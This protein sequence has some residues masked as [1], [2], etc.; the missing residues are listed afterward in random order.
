MARIRLASIILAA[1]AATMILLDA[2]FPPPIEKITDVSAYAVDREGRWLH[3]FAASEGRWR[4]A[5]DL[6]DIDPVF[7]E[8]LVR[9]EDRRFHNHPGV[10]GAAI[11]RASREAI[12][13]RRIVSGASTI[14]MQ[15]ARLLEP[16]PRTL[17]SKILEAFRALQIER[18][19]SKR[20]ILAAYLTLAPYGGNIEGVRAASLIYFGKEPSRLTDAEQ[21]LLIALPQAPEARRPDRRPMAAR[22]ARDAMLR[23]MLKAGLIT[24]QHAREAA[25]TSVPSMR[26]ELPTYAYHAAKENASTDATA[27]T[28]LDL[29][30]QSE[31]EALISRHAEQLDPH[32]TIAAVIVDHDSMAVRAAVGSTGFHVDGGWIDL[33]RAVR[34]PGSTLKPMIYAMAMDDGALGPDTLIGDMPRAFD[35][36]AP[37]N[38]DKRFRG[39]V[40]VSEALRHSLNVP[41]VAALDAIGARRFAASLRAAGF[42]LKTPASADRTDTLALALGGA[43]TRALDLATLYA[44]LANDGVMQDL[45]WVEN[46]RTDPSPHRLISASAAKRVSAILKE[47]PS[48]EGRAPSSLSQLAPGVAYKTGTS[49]G[50]RD[51][52]AA[53]YAG[54]YTVV[55]WVGRADGAPRPGMTGRKAAAPL[56]FDLFDAL[57]R[58]DDSVAPTDE[59]EMSVADASPDRMRTFDFAAPEIIFPRNG[60]ELFADG[61]ERA[62]SARG[63]TG[64]LRWYV[65]GEPVARDATSGRPLWR[66]AHPGFYGITVVDQ[67]GREA[68]AEIRVRASL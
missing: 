34:S 48:L 68:H 27:R 7:L 31:T 36:Y 15:T 5:A 32:A 20:E 51:A 55:V 13:H 47:A 25:A 49:Y 19:L 67:S 57:S 18:R 8:R 22:A 14:T 62:L 56:L 50:Y 1:F 65:D 54:A 28:T 24:S 9:I 30:M 21:A 33:T 52:W 58:H 29:L 2:L 10:D 26:R 38:F 6:D 66:P 40:S 16:R 35:G 42:M 4:F 46:A 59:V 37:E 53:G 64:A 43:G 44:A 3:G 11:L 60:A 61:V 45:R 12:R 17:P 63:G 23:R 41:A 39:E